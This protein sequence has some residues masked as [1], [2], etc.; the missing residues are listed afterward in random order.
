MNAAI[1]IVAAATFWSHGK[2]ITEIK[3]AHEM[4]YGILGTRIAPI[5]FALA[6][7]CSGQSSTITGTLAGQITMEGFLRLRMRPWLRRMI[8]RTL[9]IAPAVAVIFFWGD[10]KVMGLMILSQVVLSLQLAFAV[11]PLVK[12][13]S[14]KQKMGPFVNRRWVQVLA[15]VVTAA[16]VSL[17]GK[18][19]YEQV[20]E[21][22]GDA[23]AYGW[24]VYA[25][26]VPLIAALAVLLAVDDDPSRAARPRRGRGFGR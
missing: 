15:W 12:F 26:A 3:D 24:I 9:A 21:W 22:A 6:L 23:G 11:I 20:I 7:I 17:N 25:V 16:I 14:S 10:D 18:L 19:V 4:L 1:L 2:A 13:T 5:A 8:T